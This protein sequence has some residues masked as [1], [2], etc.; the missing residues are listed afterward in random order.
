MD[1]NTDWCVLHTQIISA[2]DGAE[3]LWGVIF[4]GNNW[5]FLLCLAPLLIPPVFLCNLQF[6]LFR[7]WNLLQTH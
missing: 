4:L 3:F 5:G 6:S 7:I 2:Q 1:V